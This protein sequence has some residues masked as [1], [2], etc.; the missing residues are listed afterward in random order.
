MAQLQNFSSF[1]I[2][3]EE[4]MGSFK[5]AIDQYLVRNDDKV[6]STILLVL[7]HFFGVAKPLNRH[8]LLI[9]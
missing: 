6:N 5:A 1:R 3:N 9:I 2:I 4:I 8:Y 7:F